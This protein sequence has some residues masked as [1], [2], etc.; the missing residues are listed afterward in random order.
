MEI[1]LFKIFI[2]GY[3]FDM[4]RLCLEVEILDSKVFIWSFFWLVKGL[5]IL[6]VF[7]LLGYIFMCLKYLVIIV[8]FIFF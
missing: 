2:F 3:D 7:V 1:L 4:L 8:G 5:L 6:M